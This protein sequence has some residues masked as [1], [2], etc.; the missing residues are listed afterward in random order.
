MGKAVRNR[1]YKRFGNTTWSRTQANHGLLGRRSRTNCHRERQTE[2]D[3]SESGMAAILWQGG[4]REYLQSFFIRIGARYRRI[5][6]RP[7][8]KPSP[9]L[10]EYKTEK[11]QELEQQAIA[12]TIDLYFGD[13]S[14]ICTEGYVPYGWQFRGEDVYIPSERGIRLNIFGMIDRNNRYDGFS[15][16]ENMTA[17]KIADFLDR[18]SM[19]IRKNTFVVLDN[20]S[21]H[22]CKLIKELRPIWEKR[23]LFL[24]FFPPYSPHLNIAETLWRILKGKWLRPVDYFFT[25]SLL[26]ATNRALAALGSELNINFAHAA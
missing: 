10:Y 26:Y 4:Q 21:V 24:F 5:R 2:R 18:M 22:R 15:T 12:G 14:H 13:E 1:R 16:T 8:G 9:Q 6:K 11:L 25:G 23:G 17:D 19:W 20:A 3:E 7:K